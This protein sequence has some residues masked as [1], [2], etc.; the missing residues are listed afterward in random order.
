V[1][2]WLA[3]RHGIAGGMRFSIA[4]IV[5][6]IAITWLLPMHHLHVQGSDVRS[7]P[8]LGCCYAIGV[9]CRSGCDAVGRLALSAV[10]NYRFLFLA[11]LGAS[12]TL[13]GW[14][15][16]SAT[17][18]ELLVF[19]MAHRLLR[20][21]RPMVLL[22]FAAGLMALRCIVLSYVTRPEWRLALEWLHGPTFGL[23]WAAGVAQA[24]TLAPKALQTTAQGLFCR[25]VDGAGAFAGALVG[26][27]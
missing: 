19:L 15:M 9:G 18:S 2:G 20:R 23:L 5:L 25:D 1:I 21:W 26:V 12:E 4:G 7:I 8:K 14:T 16:V 10:H 27:R 24:H 22:T 3:E 11:H 17:T 6:M 13:M